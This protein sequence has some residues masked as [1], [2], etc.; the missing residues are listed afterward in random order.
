MVVKIGLVLEK[1]VEVLIGRVEKEEK[2][3]ELKG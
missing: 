1:V 2:V 3:L